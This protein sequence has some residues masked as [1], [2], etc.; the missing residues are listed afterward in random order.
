[1]KRLSPLIRKAWERLDELAEQALGLIAE[2]HPDEDVT[3]LVLS[4]LG[5]DRD[6]IFRLGYDAGDTPAGQLYIFVE[7]DN[8]LGINGE[9]V[10]ETY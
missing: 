2:A 10:Y 6:G 8:K 9:L 7:F 3:E 1:M 5:F 4:E